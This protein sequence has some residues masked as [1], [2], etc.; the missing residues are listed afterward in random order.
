[1]TWRAISASVAGTAHTKNETGCQ[2]F[3]LVDFT[4]HPGWL[5]AVVAD[6]AGSA[7]LGQL[8][9]QHC[10]EQVL[11]Y[12]RAWLAQD[13]REDLSEETIRDWF[14][15]TRQ[16]LLDRAAQEEQRP[17]EYACTFLA[18]LVGPEQSAFLQIGDGAIICSRPPGDE[19]PG[20]A[21]VFWPQSGEYANTTFFVCD[22]DAEANLQL[23]LRSGPCREVAL[24][25]DGLQYLL[26]VYKDRSVYEPFFGRVFQAL[27]SDSEMHTLNQGLED[28]LNTPAVNNR[29]DDDKTLVLACLPENKGVL[30]EPTQTGDSEGEQAHH[31]GPQ[32]G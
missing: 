27:R 17:R 18:A 7:Q 23:E 10:C 25:T 5:L 2:D 1:M 21:P 6:G 9:A 16:S 20:L 19:N 29:T 28:F 24:F 32:T 22:E 26:L 3:R 13:P 31:A 11:E 8:G 4:T 12:M 14:R 30:D 15:A